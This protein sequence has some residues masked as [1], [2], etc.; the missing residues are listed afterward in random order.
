MISDTIMA[1]KQ[2]ILLLIRL[3]RCQLQ[4]ISQGLGHFTAHCVCLHARVCK[5]WHEQEELE[6]LAAETT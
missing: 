3:P 5:R 1:Q 4:L 6:V 2:S